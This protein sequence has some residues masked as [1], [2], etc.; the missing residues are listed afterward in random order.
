MTMYHP[1][2][3]AVDDNGNEQ[4]LFVYDGCLSIAECIKQFDMWQKEYGYKIKTACVQIIKDDK[5]VENC[6]YENKWIPI[7]KKSRQGFRFDENGEKIWCTVT[8][9]VGQA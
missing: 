9:D 8:E 5:T 6:Y 1:M 4:K 7:N 3:T 2:A